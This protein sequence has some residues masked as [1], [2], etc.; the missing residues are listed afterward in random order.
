MRGTVRRWV[1]ARASSGPE[2]YLQSRALSAQQ[3]AA[4]HCAG[5]WCVKETV[6]DM[7]FRAFRLCDSEGNLA[8][9]V[10]PYEPRRKFQS[11]SWWR[12]VGSHEYESCKCNGYRRSKG[13]EC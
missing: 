2:S 12:S 10:S 13:V 1:Q 11:V 8:C 9:A 6:A 7:R 4:K 3:V 5:E